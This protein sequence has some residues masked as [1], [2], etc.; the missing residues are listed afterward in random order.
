MIRKI[1]I[2]TQ[3]KKK[4]RDRVFLK[5]TQTIGIGRVMKSKKLTS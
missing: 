2:T 1:L 3:S 5:V 4:E